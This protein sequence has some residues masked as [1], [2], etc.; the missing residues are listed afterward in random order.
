M[1]AR[2][3]SRPFYRRALLIYLLAIVGPTLVLLYLG[4]QSVGRQRQAIAELTAS[5]LRLSAERLAAEMERRTRQLAEAGLADADL[6]SLQALSLDMPERARQTR[7]QIDKVRQRHPIVRHFFVVEGETVR[8]PSLR[9][10]PPRSPDPNLAQEKRWAEAEVYELRQ[11]RPDQ[12]LLAYEQCYRLPLPDPSRA[13]VLARMARCRQ[14]LNRWA[15]AERDYSALAERYGDLYDPFHRPYAVTAALERDE[16]ARAQGRSSPEPLVRLREDLAGGRW[17]L[18]AEQMDYFLAKLQD[19]LKGARSG[20]GGTDY[21]DRF[22]LARALEEGFRHQGPLRAGQVYAYAFTH[23][24]AGFQTY[25]TRFAQ[26]ALVGFACDLSWVERQLLPGLKSQ[27]RMEEAVR[28]AW[29]AGRWEPAA[30]APAQSWRTAGRRDLFVF[31]GATLLILSVLILGVVLLL[32]DV[33]RDLEWNRLRSDFVS[34]VS[35]ELKTPLTLVR[36]YAEM[37]LDRRNL[38]EAERRDFCQVI[39]RES[40]RLTHLIETVLDFSRLERGRKQYQMQESDLAAVVAGALED[41]G[42][43]LRRSGFTLQTDLASPLPPVRLDPGAV[44]QAV[45][46]LLDNAVKYSGDSTFVGVRLWASDGR[47]MV[48]VEDHGIGIPVEAQERIFQQFYRAANNAGKGG[49]GLGLY[50]VR[51]IMEAH[52]GGVEVESEVGRGSRFRLVFPQQVTA[53]T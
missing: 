39:L 53:E 3:E 50:L 27:L 24:G 21:L 47:V 32:R 14:K 5:N 17:E 9:T 26:G 43:H 15:E 41:Y 12:A 37:L 46:N 7:V 13:L 6:A 49:Y 40:D 18:S 31:T 38:P 30:P 11:Q 48:E 22:R 1:A 35:H 8:Y 23:S 44:S 19:R 20:E 36:V 25:Y 34:G 42:D 16:T 51:H 2:R 4:L 52:S 28:I 10:P 29:N 45:V 33:W